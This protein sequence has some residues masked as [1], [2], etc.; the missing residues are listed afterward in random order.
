MLEDRMDVAFEIEC[1][2]V[3][4]R[5]DSE[6][7]VKHVR[8]GNGMNQSELCPLRERVQEL[9]DEFNQFEIQH[10]SREEKL[11]ADELVDREFD[12]DARPTNTGPTAIGVI[13]ETD[14]VESFNSGIRLDEPIDTDD[15]TVPLL[16]SKSP[17]FCGCRRLPLDR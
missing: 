4:A 10:I 11:R 8:G 17:R 12:G 6:L 2:E 9:A 14:F 15:F 13:V 16:A 5:S 1:T 7:I 3:G